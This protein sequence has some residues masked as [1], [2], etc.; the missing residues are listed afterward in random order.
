VSTHLSGTRAFRVIT[1]FETWSRP[2]WRNPKSRLQKDRTSPVPI[3]SHQA[4]RSLDSFAIHSLPL[5]LHLLELPIGVRVCVCGLRACSLCSFIGCDMAG[6]YI[7][8]AVLNF[9]TRV[10]LAGEEVRRNST[11]SITVSLAWGK[12]ALKS[13]TALRRVR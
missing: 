12:S 2:P 8:I 10:E 9:V 6:A 3:C 4:P 13:G 7:A 1:N 5:F 11:R